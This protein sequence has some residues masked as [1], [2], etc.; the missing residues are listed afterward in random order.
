[1]RNRAIS[2]PQASRRRSTRRRCSLAAG[3]SER[4][5]RG[6]SSASV[7]VTVTNDSTVTSNSPRVPA[8]SWVGERWGCASPRERP[9]PLVAVD[10]TAGATVAT[11]RRDDAPHSLRDARSRLCGS[12]RWWRAFGRARARTSPVV[13]VAASVACRTPPLP[14]LLVARVGSFVNTSPIHLKN[15]P[16]QSPGGGIVGRHSLFSSRLGAPPRFPVLLVGCY[17]LGDLIGK[18]SARQ[19]DGAFASGDGVVTAANNRV[20]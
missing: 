3:A 4:P 11:R 1:M 7:G 12:R 10:H 2:C 14:P 8:R 6:R 18:A 17:N 15:A 20:V 16:R 5:A 9:F 13:R 19:R